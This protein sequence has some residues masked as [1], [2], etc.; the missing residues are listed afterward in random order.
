MA[1]IPVFMSVKFGT[2]QYILCLHVSSSVLCMELKN[3]EWLS[4][5]VDLFKK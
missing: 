1:S 3:N 4:E 2:D 5:I